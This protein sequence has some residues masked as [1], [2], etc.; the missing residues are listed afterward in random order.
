MGPFYYPCMRPK[1]DSSLLF[2]FSQAQPG[3]SFFSLSPSSFPFFSLPMDQA[4]SPQPWPI[5]EP[6]QLP[7]YSLSFLFLSFSP[8]S[9]L[10]QAPLSSF[11]SFLFPFH[12]LFFF[13]LTARPPTQLVSPL[14]PHTP[15]TWSACLHLLFHSSNSFAQRPGQLKEE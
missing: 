13:G 3:S 8:S 4:C 1:P 2:S 12:L 14:N 15:R 9:G 11:F 6:V 10:A 5:S 7:T